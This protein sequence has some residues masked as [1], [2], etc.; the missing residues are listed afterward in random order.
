MANKPR[1]I[2]SSH[3]KNMSRRI[4]SATIGTHAQGAPVKSSRRVGTG[5]VEFSNPRKSN[6]AKRGEVDH[7]LPTTSSRESETAYS[8]RVSQRRYTESFQRKARVKGI[9]IAIICIVAIICIAGGVGAAAYFGSVSDKMSL[10]DSNAATALVAPSEGKATYVLLEG[11]F[12]QAGQAYEGPDML[13]LARIDSVKKSVAFISIPV[14]LQVTLNDGNIHKI[15]DAQ[16][17]GGDSYLIST[18]ASVTGVS[19]SHLVKTDGPGLVSLVD[20]L[21]GLEIDVAQEVDDPN[22]GALYIA[23]GL[24]TLDGQAVLTLCRAANFTDAIETRTANQRAVAEALLGKLLDTNM[25][26]IIPTLDSISSMVK[27]D[28]SAGDAIAALDVL[29]DLPLDQAYSLQLPGYGTT[30]TAT[31]VEYFVVSSTEWTEMLAALDAGEDPLAENEAVLE[32]DP[33]SFT[34][35]VQNGSG[36]TG[37]ASLMSERLTQGGFSV[38]ASGNAER[39]V[40]NETLVVYKDAAF[41]NAAEALVKYLGTGRAIASNGYYTFDT[42]VLVVLGKD[43]QPL[44]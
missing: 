22:A 40:Y 3:Q 43:W 13:M 30:N 14:N 6:R 37:G 29:R 25:F 26:S 21:G 33:A 39:Y 34:I 5:A 1:K 35:T 17:I 41:S 38:A 24:Q 4:R 18:V 27:T 2:S 12:S 10:G 42:D 23:Q 7:V 36:L 11:E 9:I 31:G 44:N 15:A 16:M 20:T 19:V 28:Y 8:K 32:V